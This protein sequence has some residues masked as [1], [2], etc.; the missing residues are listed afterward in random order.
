MYVVLLLN[1]HC[2]VVT[3]VPTKS[4]RLHEL[5]LE[6][7]SFHLVTTPFL[8]LFDSHFLFL[9]PT[10]GLWFLP[11]FPCLF[12]DL[13]SRPFLLRT[14][15]SL[16]TVSNGGLSNRSEE[17]RSRRRRSRGGRANGSSTVCP[18]RDRSTYLGVSR[19]Y[20]RSSSLLGTSS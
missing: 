2:G 17:G 19:P 18:E 3:F 14:V 7:W 9:L 10:G 1:R 12:I 16:F 13:F 20:K 4:L 15:Y 11:F 6:V 5:L 8:T